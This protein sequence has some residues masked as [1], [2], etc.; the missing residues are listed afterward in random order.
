MQK[1]G[2]FPGNE[3][4]SAINTRDH[5]KQVAISTGGINTGFTV[6]QD[7]H[8]NHLIMANNDL[9]TAFCIKRARSPP[10]Y[11]PEL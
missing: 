5:L 7:I 1:R 10:L 2:H 11:I 6:M 8:S 3:I 9:T 4:L